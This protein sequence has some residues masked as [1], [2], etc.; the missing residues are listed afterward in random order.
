[1]HHT[2][3]RVF[4]LSNV[5]GLHL[6]TEIAISLAFTTSLPGTFAKEMKAGKKTP[7]ALPQARTKVLISGSFPPWAVAQDA[8]LVTIDLFPLCLGKQQTR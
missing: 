5:L 4:G 2:A 7:A 3:K 6:P 8:G 1:M